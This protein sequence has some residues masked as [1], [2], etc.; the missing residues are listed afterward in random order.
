[1]Q[2]LQDQNKANE[3][4][5]EHVE[6]YVKCDGSSRLDNNLKLTQEEDKVNMQWLQDQNNANAKWIQDYSKINTKWFRDQ[7]ETHTKDDV[8]YSDE[9]GGELTP[10]STIMSG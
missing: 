5:Q 10:T 2:C 6:A 8:D 9:D 1:M 3:W 7:M 4:I